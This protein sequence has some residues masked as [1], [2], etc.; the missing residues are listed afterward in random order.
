LALIKDQVREY[1]LPVI[2]KKDKRF[3]N[4]RFQRVWTKGPPLK[5]GE[6]EAVET[7]AISQRV[8]I[9]ILRARLDRLLPEPLMRVQEREARQ[10]RQLA[11]LLL[12]RGS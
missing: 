6:H 12:R 7:E 11:A 9:D 2:V 10:R 4:R 1:K 3:K 8:L 5:P